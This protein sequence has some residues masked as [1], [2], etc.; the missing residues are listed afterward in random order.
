MVMAMVRNQDS[1]QKSKDR[2]LMKRLEDFNGTQMTSFAFLSKEEVAHI[3]AY[4]KT[5]SAPG[6]IP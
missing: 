3:A 6:S 1:L 5:A 4:V 2:Y